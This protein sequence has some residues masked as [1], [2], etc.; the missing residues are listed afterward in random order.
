MTLFRVGS[1]NFYSY[2]EELCK[3]NSSKYLIILGTKHYQ[4]PI[5]QIPA[6]DIVQV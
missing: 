4:I 5:S 2:K 3:C 1:T 6:F